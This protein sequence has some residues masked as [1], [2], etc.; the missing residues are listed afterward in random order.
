MV[1][2]SPRAIKGIWDDGYSLDLHTISSELVGHDEFGHERFAT[3]RSEIGELLYSLKYHNNRSTIG[4]IAA[5]AA[6]FIRNSTT[7]RPHLLVPVPPSKYR[8][9]Q[10]V[11]ALATK[12][13]KALEVDYCENCVKKVRET[14]GLKDV[15]V[16]AEREKLLSRAFQITG[17]TT[18][19][20]RVLLFDDLFRSGATMNSVCAVLRQQ[21]KAAHIFALA[22]TKTRSLR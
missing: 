16:F 6:N 2:I 22:V 3:T 7:W 20:K 13:A 4:E 1:N 18:E 8:P 17:S 9:F 15:S 10:P 5:T 19:G 21:G 12:L 11:F 14:P